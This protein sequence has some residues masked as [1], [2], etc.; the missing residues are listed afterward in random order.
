MHMY[1]RTHVQMCVLYRRQLTL[2][3]FAVLA[4]FFHNRRLPNDFIKYI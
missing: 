4:I 3:G 1:T 2:K